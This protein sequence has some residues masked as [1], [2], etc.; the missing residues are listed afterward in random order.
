MD[1]YALYFRVNAFFFQ[2]GKDGAQGFGQVLFRLYFLLFQRFLRLF[3]CDSEQI[4]YRSV[5]TVV[6]FF[7]FGFAFFTAF[8]LGHSWM[9]ACAVGIR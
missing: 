7:G 4:E 5:G 3:A 6:A 9:D 1:G 2:S 8:T